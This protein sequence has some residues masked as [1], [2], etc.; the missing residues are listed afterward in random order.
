MAYIL[1]RG[2]SCE[3]LLM[4]EKSKVIKAREEQGVLGNCPDFFCL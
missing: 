2:E 4:P 1:N 3:K